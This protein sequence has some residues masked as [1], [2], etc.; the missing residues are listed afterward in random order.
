M[1]EI[2]YS[3]TVINFERD[4]L[5]LIHE[6]HFPQWAFPWGVIASHCP[7]IM[8]E[9]WAIGEE[10]GFCMN[11]EGFKRGTD[12]RDIPAKSSKVKES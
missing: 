5:K 4:F 7:S 2:H 9:R 8:F 11:G 1:F 6:H 10:V 12:G 3:L